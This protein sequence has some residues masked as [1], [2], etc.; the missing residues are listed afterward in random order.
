[1]AFS[2]EV[3]KLCRT[4]DKLTAGQATLAPKEDD[5]SLLTLIIKPID[6]YYNGGRIEFEISIPVEYPAMP[7]HVK[8]LTPILHPNIG[9]GFRDRWDGEICLNILDEDWKADT[10]GLDDVVNGIM[11][12]LCDEEGMNFDDVLNGDLWVLDVWEEADRRE[13]FQAII[14]GAW[15][16]IDDPSQAPVPLSAYDSAPD[17][18]WI[19]F[20][21]CRDPASPTADHTYGDPGHSST[22]ELQPKL[23]AHTQAERQTSAPSIQMLGKSASLPGNRCAPSPLG[24]HKCC[25]EPMPHK[26]VR[27]RTVKQEVNGIAPSY[28]KEVTEVTPMCNPS[29]L[30]APGRLSR[31]P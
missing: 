16:N 20:E 14:G 15:V 11:F 24:L 28:R 9:T 2:K 23:L 12:L 3:I 21:S 22:D 18:S 29:P 17:A 25:S 7:P 13:W 1:M 30:E 8:C 6:G 27:C 31:G 26:W 19:R 10:M 5:S 4:I